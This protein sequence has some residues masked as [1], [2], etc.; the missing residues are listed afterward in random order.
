[1][2]QINELAAALALAQ[3][4]MKNATMNRVNPHFKSRYADLAS[5]LDAVRGPLAANGLSIVQTMNPNGD[6]II[7]RTTLMHAS[8]QSISTDYPIPLGLK[9]HEMGSHLT[10]ARRYSVSALIC[11]S[12][13]E[14]DDGAE[15]MKA[16]K[17]TNGTGP[18]ITPAQVDAINDLIEEVG[19]NRQIFLNYFKIQSVEQLPARDYERAVSGLVAKRQPQ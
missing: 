14:D 19:Q 11:N 8:G 13:D 2:D 7:L 5:V 6:T 12:A 15:A 1:M 3:G 16:A 17:V 4:A 10:Y 18:A 9:P